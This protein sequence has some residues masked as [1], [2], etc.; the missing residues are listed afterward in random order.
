MVR[1]EELRY[2]EPV[3]RGRFTPISSLSL[4]GKGNLVGRIVTVFAGLGMK[5]I[6]VRTEIDNGTSKTDGRLICTVSSSSVLRL[7]DV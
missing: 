4:W 6:V 5:P 1:K 7:A 2:A 3:P